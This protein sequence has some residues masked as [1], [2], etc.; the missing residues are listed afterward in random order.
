VEKVIAIITRS[1]AVAE[2]ADRTA[3]EILGVGSRG[4]RVGVRGWKLYRCIPW[5]AL[6]IFT[7]SYTSF[8]VGC[9]V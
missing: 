2:I 6:P 9:I 4:L 3:L 7:I 1:P 5:M 8:D